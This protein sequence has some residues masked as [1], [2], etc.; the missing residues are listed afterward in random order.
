MS[1]IKVWFS[2][3]ALLCASASACPLCHTQ[4]GEQVRASICNN[5][6]VFNLLAIAAPFPVFL[7]LVAVIYFGPPK[8]DRSV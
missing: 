7:G 5:R 2:T 1:P 4:T 6:L 8:R 3:A